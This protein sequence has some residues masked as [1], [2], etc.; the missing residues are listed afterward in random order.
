VYQNPYVRA[1]EDIL[2]TPR[3][4]TF[5]SFR[6]DSPSF[7]IVVPLT[8]DGK[9]V[10]V[11]NYRPSVSAY[12]LELPGGRIEPGEPKE[13]TA[14]RELAEET[15]Y[16]ARRL[17]ELGWFY[18]SPARMMSVGHV[19]LARGL[20]AGRRRLDVTEDMRNVEIP[21]ELA[22]RN[23]R[24]GRFHDGGAMTGLALAEPTLRGLSRTIRSKTLIPRVAGRGRSGV[25]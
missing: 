7:A 3:G 24:S 16:R 21:V 22:Y 1:H 18:P 17:V 11:R 12:V 9:I 13:R 4:G 25:G 20:R 8:T 2:R 5:T 6:L 19:F 23:L 10:F 15:G 14:R